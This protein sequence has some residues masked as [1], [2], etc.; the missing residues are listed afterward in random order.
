MSIWT[1]QY[2]WYLFYTKSIDTTRSWFAPLTVALGVLSHSTCGSHCWTPINVQALSVAT[3]GHFLTLRHF[4]PATA[5]AGCLSFCS[6]MPFTDIWMSSHSQALYW[7]N[8]W[9][10]DHSFIVFLWWCLVKVTQGLPTILLLFDC[11]FSVSRKNRLFFYGPYS[12]SLPISITS[13]FFR[14][15]PG[16]YEGEK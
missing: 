8:A 9:T 12:S 16:I 4:Q 15:T 2:L 5:S 1:H 13:F 10:K 3:V 7:M 6:L 14:F 11:L